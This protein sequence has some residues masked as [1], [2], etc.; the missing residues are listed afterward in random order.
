L[1]LQNR[2]V[3]SISVLKRE[4]ADDRGYDEDHAVEYTRAYAQL[5]SSVNQVVRAKILA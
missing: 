1:S 5:P 2:L 3:Q 4:V